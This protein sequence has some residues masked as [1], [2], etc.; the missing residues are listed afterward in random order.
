ML[1]NKEVM[2]KNISKYMKMSNMSRRDLSEKLD[3]AYTTVTDWI[4]AKNYPRIDKIEMMANMWGVQKS[5]LVED[6]QLV[7]NNHV[8]T[9]TINIPVVNS[10]SAGMPTYNETDVID[11]ISVMNTSIKNDKEYFGLIVSGDSMD[12]E[13]KDGD[14]VVVEK[15]AQ[16]ENGD[17]AVVAV[18]GYDATVKRIKRDYD[19]N[20]IMLM[21]ESTNREHETQIYSMNDDVHIIGKVVG[22]NR[23]Y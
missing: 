19:K 14:I 15:D 18:N 4:N 3:V 13:F 7:N 6:G 1:G 16:V 11:Y 2:A 8:V 22:M 17:I 10:V 9:P 23:S 20:I 21:P 5:D 12:L